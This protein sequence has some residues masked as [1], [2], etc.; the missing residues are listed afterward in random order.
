MCMSNV[1]AVLSKPEKTYLSLTP[2][3]EAVIVEVSTVQAL[4]LR[5]NPWRLNGAIHLPSVNWTYRVTHS[6][7]YS[8]QTNYLDMKVLTF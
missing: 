1:L 8:G 4:R 5:A 6:G 3:L 7:F 2:Q